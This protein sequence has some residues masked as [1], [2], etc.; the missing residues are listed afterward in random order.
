MIGLIN[1]DRLG[2]V[3]ARHPQVE[4]IVAGHVHSTMVRRF[5]GT[6]AMTCSATHQQIFPDLQRP[7]RLAVIMEPP[8]CLV[9]VWR[10]STG[11]L[12]H[13]NLIGDHGRLVALHDGVSWVPQA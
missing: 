6:I 10:E 2:A 13:T 9:H 4:R 7:E 8:A 5:Y 11:M 1:A 12:T 3:I